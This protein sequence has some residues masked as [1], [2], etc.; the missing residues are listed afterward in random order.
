MTIIIKLQGGL[1]NQ[2]FQ[3]ALGR[4]LSEHLNTTLKLD[5]SFLLDR[6]FRESHTFRNYELNI[7]NIDVKFASPEETCPYSSKPKL[8]FW[9][10]QRRVMGY[11][12]YKEK[13]FSFNPEIFDIKSNTYIDGFWQSPKYFDKIKNTILKDFSFQDN[14]LD[15]IATLAN[16]IENSNS[17]C[18]HVRRGDYVSLSK[19]NKFHG[20]KGIDYF[21]AAVSLIAK[22]ITDIKIYVFSDDISWCVQNLKFEFT[23]TFV[24]YEYPH[25]KPKDYFRLMK[26]CKHFIISNSSFSWWAAWLNQNPQKIVIAPEKWFNDPMIDTSDLIPENWVR[27]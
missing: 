3:Y 9:K 12:F 25:R 4:A 7:F 6:K 13:D 5:L 14:L 11:S 18:L 21:D 26:S 10:L 19:A 15:N 20:L 23:T 24:E 27:I 17:I 8:I 22:T 2:M 16:E 1:G